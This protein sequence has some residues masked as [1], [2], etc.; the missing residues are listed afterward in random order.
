MDENVHQ[1]SSDNYE[2]RENLWDEQ[3]PASPEERAMHPVD[4]P[5]NLD[6]ELPFPE[7]VGTTD[8]IVSVRDQE[9]YMP[10]TDPPVLPGGREAIHM[11][12]GFG[13]SPEEETALE[14]L[15]RGDEDIR[16]EAL[17]IL[18]QDSD[19]STLPLDVEV[20]EGVIRLVGAVPSAMDGE[21]AADLL[22]YVPGVVEVVDDTEINPDAAG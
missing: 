8:V 19:T 7:T 13:V 14:P 18:R 2:E 12:T 4:E 17:L 6:E 15:P 5:G 9:P 16:D 1:N 11:A 10:P 22:S 21:R 20:D 3:W